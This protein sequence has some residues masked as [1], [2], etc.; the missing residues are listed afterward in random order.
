MTNYVNITKQMNKG[1]GVGAS[2]TGIPMKVYRITDTS[3]GDFIADANLL[4]QM[5]ADRAHMQKRE[6]AFESAERLETYWY[7][8]LINNNPLLLGDVLISSDPYLNA[9]YTTVT[10]STGQFIGFCLAGQPPTDHAIAARLD[11][12]AQFYRPNLD[13]T[14]ETIGEQT[15][16]YWDSTQPQSLPLLCVDGVFQ[17]GAT[18]DT[19]AKIPIGSMPLNNSG[20]IYSAPTANVTTQERRRIYVPPLPGFTLKATDEFIISDG[21]RYRLDSNYYQTA[22]TVGGQYMASKVVSGSGD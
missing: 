10:Y 22:G 6:A 11:T 5:W 15:V 16:P 4:F 20:D 1:C 8:L 2:H 9:G 13:P 14:T 17:L 7:E 18:T 3:N 12:L 21:S 19:A